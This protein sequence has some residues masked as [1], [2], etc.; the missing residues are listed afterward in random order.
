MSPSPLISGITSQERGTGGEIADLTIRGFNPKHAVQHNLE[1]QARA[2]GL[3]GRW[4]AIKRAYREANFLLGDVVKVT[5]TSK[6]VGDL[7]QF[8]VQ[9]DLDTKAVLK[10]A[11]TLSF[12]S[13]VHDFMLGRLGQPY[14]GFPEPLHTKILRGE[15]PIQGRPG[16]SLEPM[17]LDQLRVD[18][19]DKYAVKLGEEDVL[20]AAL[21]PQVFAD[22]MEFR[23]TYS[24]VSVIPTLPFLAPLTPGEEISIEIEHGKTLVIEFKDI[25][26]LDD[27]GKRPV[28]FELNGQPRTLLIPDNAA[29]EDVV[30]RERA[31]PNDAGS[32]GAPML[33][34]IATVH[35]EVGQEVE[36]QQALLTMTAMKMETIVTAPIAGTVE[37]ILVQ[38]DDTLAAGDLLLTIGS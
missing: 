5:P 15:K 2:L 38:S 36:K 20:S 7:A 37:S 32:L 10:Q 13:S 9:N 21:Y 12:P 34:V 17:D 30:K 22:Y 4:T 27:N 3:A 25:G 35:V 1:F 24:D 28:Y 18:L 29:Q 8:M 33:G 11:D 19:E 26:E 16:E 6:V 31:N 23:R 14:G